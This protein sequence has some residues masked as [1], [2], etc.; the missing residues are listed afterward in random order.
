[1]LVPTKQVGDGGG[2]PDLAA[3]LDLAT[4]GALPP[5][6]RRVFLLGARK[7]NLGDFIVIIGSTRVL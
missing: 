5:G 3:A 7:G 1:M 4:D 6:A 2:A